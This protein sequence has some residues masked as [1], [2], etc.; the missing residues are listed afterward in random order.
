[1]EGMFPMIKEAQSLISGFDM[2]GLEKLTQSTKG[3]KK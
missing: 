1:M 2:K 3:G